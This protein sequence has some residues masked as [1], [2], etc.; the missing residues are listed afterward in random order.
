MRVLHFFKTYYPN[1]FGGV[2]QMIHQLAKGSPDINHTVLSLADDVS[3]RFE[4]ADCYDVKY[5]KLNFTLA[6]T[7]FS[8]PA[9]F[10]FKRLVNQADIVH[11]H[12]PNPF[13]DLLH[14]LCR[15]KKPSVLTYHSDIIKQ[16]RFLKIYQPLMHRFLK[17]VDSIVATSNHYIQSSEVLKNYTNKLSVIPIGIQDI[18]NQPTLF[19]EHDEYVRQKQ[20]W[21]QKITKP[22][23]LFVGSLRYYK[24]LDLLLESLKKL[25]QSKHGADILEKF[26]FVIA[27]GGALRQSLQQNIQENGLKNVHIL[28]EVDELTKHIL[29]Q[30]AYAFVFPSHLRTEAFGI[31]LVEAAMHSK[32]MLSFDIGTGSSF[33]NQNQVTGE[34]LPLSTDE[35]TQ[36][37][38][39]WVC[40]P[41]QIKTWGDQ[42]RQHFLAHL[43]IKDMAQKYHAVYHQVLNRS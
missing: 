39:R 40:M 18:Y 13:A 34:V 1:S 4:G 14:Q 19:L 8:L 37:I 5:S 17:Q 35:L 11:Y 42:A 32:A 21:Q 30:Q 41:K 20:H 26:D 2:E 15:V 6:S 25:S 33:I 31:S 16:K 22:Y 36:A 12:F 23:F 29:Y 24:G 43:Q 28:G 7:G 9:V 27:G 3:L 10:D 38:Q